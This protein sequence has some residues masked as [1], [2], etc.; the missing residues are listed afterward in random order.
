VAA[1]WHDGAFH[2]TLPSVSEGFPAE[3]PAGLAMPRS[4]A[5]WLRDRMLTSSP[6]TMLKFAV[7]HRPDADS[8]VP[9][10][11]SVLVSADG[12]RADVLDDARRF[13]TLMNTASLVYNLLLAE[14]CEHEG[15]D[16]VEKPVDDNT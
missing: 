6:G 5:A 8:S 13:S 16:R 11:D 1:V 2:S 4:E 14:A 10:E 7:E 3:V 12:E 15:F 9:W